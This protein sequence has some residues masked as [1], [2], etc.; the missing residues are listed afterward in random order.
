MPKVLGGSEGGGRFR[1]GEVPLFSA[2]GQLFFFDRLDGSLWMTGGAQSRRVRTPSLW[3]TLKPRVELYKGLRVI[4]KEKK[5][6]SR[7]LGSKVSTSSSVNEG[8]S[9]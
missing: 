3:I 1:M 7:A 5:K 4:K 6:V 8:L 2:M 9:R